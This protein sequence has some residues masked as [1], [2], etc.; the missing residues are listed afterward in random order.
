MPQLDP[1][2]YPAQL[3]WLVLTFGVFFLLMWK[4]ALPRISDILE[5]RQN[6]IDQDLKRAEVLK[7]EAEEVMADYESALAGSRAN[8]LE[9][10]R[11]VKDQAAE[12]TARQ[13]AG[14]TAQLSA[15]LATA[16]QSIAAGRTAAIAGIRSVAADLAAATV[17]RLSGQ[18]ADSERIDAAIQAAEGD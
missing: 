17:E 16:E 14:L 5:S 11:A 15:E 9:E 18:T 2:N 8:A 3:F 1:A 10:M 12:E 6:R 13:N 4:V 7:K